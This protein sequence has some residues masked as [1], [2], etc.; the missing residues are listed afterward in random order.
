[1]NA[2]GTFVRSAYALQM[3]T[4]GFL[5]ARVRHLAATRLT[6]T[7]TGARA[8][9]RRVDTSLHETDCSATERP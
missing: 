6:E 4:K 2:D 3:A 7:R 5:Q 1:V 9:S 8:R